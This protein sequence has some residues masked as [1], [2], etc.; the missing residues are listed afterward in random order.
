M[1]GRQGSGLKETTQPAASQFVKFITSYQDDQAKEDE[2]DE[3]CR[4]SYASLRITLH[5]YIKHTQDEDAFNM[6]S[7]IVN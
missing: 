4:K 2:M 3:A 6:A 7:Y 5:A 1:F